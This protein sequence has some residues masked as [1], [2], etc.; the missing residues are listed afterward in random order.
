M[1]LVDMAVPMPVVEN[2]AMGGFGTRGGVAGGDEGTEG[3]TFVFPLVGFTG[4]GGGCRAGAGSGLCGVSGR[5]PERYYCGRSGVRVAR[6]HDAEVVAALR[7]ADTSV[8]SGSSWIGFGE[9]KDTG[10]WLW[11]SQW[12]LFQFH[13]IH[14][15]W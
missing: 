9:S 3:E 6:V 8:T 12:H 1:V 15:P 5:S 10:K 14:F 13:L 11:Y 2:E 7:R 4:A